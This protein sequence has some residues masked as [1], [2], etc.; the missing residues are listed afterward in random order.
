MKLL[1]T[2]H[3]FF[4]PLWIR[5]LVVAVAA[6]WSFFEFA[7]GSPFWGVVFL[8]FAGI[9]VWGFFFDFNPDEPD[10]QS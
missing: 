9:S 10:K 8:G 6:G 1:D 3:P 7:T 4:K 2:N 5:L